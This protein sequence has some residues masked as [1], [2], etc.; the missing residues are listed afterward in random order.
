MDQVKKQ[1]Q[2]IVVACFP[3]SGSTFLARKLA[4]LPTCVFEPLVP[5]GER[6]EQELDEGVIREVLRKHECR[7][8]IG[9]QHVRLNWHTA[10]L[11]MK[12]P[13]RFVVLVRDLMDCLISLDDH[14]SNE[15]KLFPQSFWSNRLYDDLS[16]AKLSRIHAVTV[17]NAPWFIN[18]YLSWV[19]WKEE[20]PEIPPPLFLTYSQLFQNLESTMTSLV[21]EFGIKAGQTDIMRVLEEQTFSRLNKGISGRGRE[22]FLRD[23][24]AASALDQIIQ[25]YPTVDFSLIYKHIRS[26]ERFN[27]AITSVRTKVLSVFTN[28]CL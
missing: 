7:H 22:Y 24:A 18:F 12:Y 6:R 27:R 25:C 11:A 23:R 4:A 20:Y 16:K 15:S 14:M 28:K 17:T 21:S 13:I 2:I 3:K 19:L 5:F 26:R 9:Q 10:N 1:T 8:V